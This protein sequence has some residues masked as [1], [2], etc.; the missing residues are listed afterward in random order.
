MRFLASFGFHCARQA[1]DDSSIGLQALKLRAVTR[2]AQAILMKFNLFS[3]GTQQAFLF[4]ND[5]TRCAPGVHRSV[6]LMKNRTIW[7]MVT[8]PPEKVRYTLLT[9][10]HIAPSSS[11]SSLTTL[12]MMG[13]IIPRLDLPINRTVSFF[14]KY[15][16]PINITIVSN[17]SP[18]S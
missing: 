15:R 7:I 14:I 16:Q 6:L 3:G 4:P 1:K 11:P 17:V 5:T 18:W 8:K 9:S 10:L 12:L 2:Q 13:T